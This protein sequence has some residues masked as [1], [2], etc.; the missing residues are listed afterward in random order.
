MLSNGVAQVRLNSAGA[1]TG[2]FML[3]HGGVEALSVVD[4]R[5]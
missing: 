4:T 2:L 3:G 1:R 5:L